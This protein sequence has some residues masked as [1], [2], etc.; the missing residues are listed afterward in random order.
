MSRIEQAQGFTVLNLK[1]H[2][3]ELLQF[4]RC[5]ITVLFYKDIICRFVLLVEITEAISAFKQ[6][7]LRKFYLLAMFRPVITACSSF[8]EELKF[9]IF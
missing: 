7:R 3:V 1:K 5:L 9:Q 4:V 8:K 2:T 6:S